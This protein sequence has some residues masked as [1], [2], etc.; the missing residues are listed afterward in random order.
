MKPTALIVDDDRQYCEDL[1]KLLSRKYAVD[2]ICDAAHAIKR[3]EEK[4]PD[5]VLLDIDLGDAADGFEILAGIKRMQ[6]RPSVIML[7]WDNTIN[8]AV[9]AIKSGATEYFCKEWSVDLL[10]K[11][12]EKT[13]DQSL[14]LRRMKSLEKVVDDLYGELIY[15]DPVSRKIVEMA[16]RY[17]KSD[18]NVL[19]TGEMGTGKEMLARRVHAN[20]NRRGGPFVGVNCAA[21]AEKLIE[22]TL[23][24]YEKGA[25]TGATMR[26]DGLLRAANRGTLFL[27]E[28]GHSS[29]DFQEKLLRAVELR[30]FSRVGGTAEVSSDFRLICATSS[31]LTRDIEEGRFLE[32]LY[33]RINVCA[34]HLPPLKSRKGDILP[35]AL[36]FLTEQSR[37]QSKRIRGFTE[38]AQKALLGD[39]WRGN[40]R[41]LRNAVERAVIHCDGDRIDLPDLY[42]DA[43]YS[44]SPV[45]YKEA[46]TRWEDR[47]QTRYLINL[48]NFS[49]GSVTK[50]A[51][52]SGLPRPSLS[53]MLKQRGINPEDFR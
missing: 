24:G 5:V 40:V 21:I 29:K 48:L 7:T 11:L 6:E 28:I 52:M 31:D 22:S 38:D 13:I 12:M 32:E 36:K 37:R 49:G 35:L 10:V 20:S 46:K 27:D 9:R 25:F 39:P 18:S 16:D 1:S 4:Q 23:F 14:Q 45:P 33:F 3:I 8:S 42:L 26:K 41:A 30:R 51:E 44:T 15:K 47:E 50:A 43:S 2:F 17:A 34:L 19:I 53:R